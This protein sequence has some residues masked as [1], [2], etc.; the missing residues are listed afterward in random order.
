MSLLTDSGTVEPNVLVRY[1]LWLR[2][3]LTCVFSVL[4]WLRVCIYILHYYALV[5]SCMP[6]AYLQL[7]LALDS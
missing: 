7:E 5:L 3:A 4:L 2:I 6:R 1:S